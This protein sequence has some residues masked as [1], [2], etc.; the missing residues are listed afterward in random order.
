M[1]SARLRPAPTSSAPSPQYNPETNTAA[2]PSEALRLT[3]VLARKVHNLKYVPKAARRSWAQ[4]VALT[5]A[6]VFWHNNEQAWA[7]WHMLAQG[8]LWAPAKQDPTF[9][10]QL[11]AIIRRRCK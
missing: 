9:K 1:A 6:A 2:A 7:E 4:C 8:L 11:A 3:S 10:Q 5:A